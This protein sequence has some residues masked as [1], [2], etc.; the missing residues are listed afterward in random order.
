MKVAS[1]LTLSLIVALCC[2]TV[3]PLA[4]AQQSSPSSP[5]EPAVIDAKASPTPTQQPV[6]RHFVHLIEENKKENR[7]VVK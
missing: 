4:H 3:A 2:C 1:R 5:A 6:E 7:R